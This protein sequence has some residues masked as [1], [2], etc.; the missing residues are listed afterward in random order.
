[1]PDKHKL[2]LERSRELLAKI[3]ESVNR[4]GVLVDKNGS[5]TQAN[6]TAD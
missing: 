3:T 5:Q 4:Q 6:D 2:I 1:M